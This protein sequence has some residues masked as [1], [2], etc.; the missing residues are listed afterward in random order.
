[1]VIA[2]T[3]STGAIDTELDRPPCQA[4]TIVVRSDSKPLRAFHQQTTVFLALLQLFRSVVAPT[5]HPEVGVDA[6]E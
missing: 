3:G 4:S 1:M 5:G 6:G 2:V